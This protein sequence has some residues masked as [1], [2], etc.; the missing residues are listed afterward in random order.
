MIRKS[1]KMRGGGV[2][3]WLTGKEEEEQPQKYEQQQQQQ[4]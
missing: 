1:R 4:Q 2:W 3:D